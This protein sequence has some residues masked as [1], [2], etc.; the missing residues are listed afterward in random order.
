MGKITAPERLTEA[1]DI[2]DFKSRQPQL[3]EWLRRKALSNET[4]GGCRTYVTTDGERVIGFYCLA[5]GAVAHAQAT[6]KARR[7]MPD[8]IPAVIVGRMGVDETFERQGIGR[9]LIRDSVIRTLAAAEVIG[10]RA[11][12][13]HAKSDEARR[14]YVERC[15]LSES[16]IDPMTLMVTLSDA[17]KALGI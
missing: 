17:R 9:G 13:I 7:N 12:L 14:F 11:I 2:A 3:D 5:T 1:H 8:P 4:S 15:G 6:G 10:V 16:P